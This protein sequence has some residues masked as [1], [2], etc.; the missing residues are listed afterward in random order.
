MPRVNVMNDAPNPG[1]E[2]ALQQGCKCP[3]LDNAHGM[4]W[5]GIDGIFVISESCPL[6]G[7]HQE[8]GDERNEH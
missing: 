8:N 2:A 3:V 1:S 6:H 5:H 4:G 7:I